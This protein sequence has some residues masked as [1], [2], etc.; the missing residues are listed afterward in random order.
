MS[1]SPLFFKRMAESVRQRGVSVEYH[2]CSADPDSLDGIVLVELGVAFIDGTSPHVVDPE[3]PGAV[4][5]IINF[6]QFWDAR[7]IQ[8]HKKTIIRLRGH[9]KDAYKRAYRYLGAARQAFSEIE[10]VHQSAL[11]HGVLNQMAA[12]LVEELLSER[13]IAGRPG[14]T[15][16]LFGSAITPAGPRNYLETL[17]GPA[18]RKV[19]I[20]GRPGT[21]KATLVEK[22]A[23]HAMERGYAIECFHCPFDPEKTQHVLIPEID[24]AITTSVA[25]HVWSGAVDMIVDTD[26]AL[27]LSC[28]ERHQDR[29]CTADD[30]YQNLFTAAVQALGE[31]RQAHGE[32]ETYYIPHMDFAAVDAAFADVRA[33]IDALLPP[34][35]DAGDALFHNLS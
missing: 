6:G 34:S 22:V 8:D 28:V 19:V 15:R 1:A 10:T 30:L 35:A 20:T 14:R 33:Q 17:I 9:I 24:T 7:G 31:A 3:Y 25:P 12:T 13:W 23:A 29:I 18:R 21:G 2:H 5:E 16:H 32:L 27:D 26:D 4:D 11:E